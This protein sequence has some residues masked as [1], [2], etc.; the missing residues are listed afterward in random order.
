M[1]K[2][3]YADWAHMAQIKINAARRP[4][5]DKGAP[6]GK[7]MSEPTYSVADSGSAIG[8]PR[9]A[10]QR[11]T[12]EID[13]AYGRGTVKV[14]VK[15]QNGRTKLEEAPATEA[16]LRKALEHWKTRKPRTDAS[17]TAQSENVSSLVRRLEAMRKTRK[18][19]TAEE[20]P[21]GRTRH[22][23]SGPAL[24]QGPNMAPVRPTWRNPKTGEVEPAGARL[25]G[26]LTDRLDRT[27]ADERPKAH[28]TPAQRARYRRKMRKQ[29]AKRQG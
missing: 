10:I 18:A 14:P 3:T 20:S 13:G 16:N 17:R 28:Y 7:F 6:T 1:S 23:L 22:V 21:E 4:R 27:V 9:N 11:R 19:M 24:V 12:V 25:D 26:S 29:A 15:G 8:D 5:A 2:I